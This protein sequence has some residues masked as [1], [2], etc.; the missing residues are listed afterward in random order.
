MRKK[1][2]WVFLA[3]F[4]IMI[5]ILLWQLLPILVP[6]AR[7]EPRDNTLMDLAEEQDDS[8]GILLIDIQ[9]Q[10]TAARFHVSALGVYV[11]VIDEN[12]AASRAGLCSGD[13]IVSLNGYPISSTSDFS[14]FASQ[15]G[16][17][18]S[19]VVRRETEPQTFVAIVLPNAE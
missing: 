14:D 16:E 17:A 13:R 18:I 12:S 2:L 1:W 19:L 3:A 11:L 7:T 8:L 4:V 15:R 6:S 5:A 9:T 10:E